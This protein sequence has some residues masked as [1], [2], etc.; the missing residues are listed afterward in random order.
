MPKLNEIRLLC[1]NYLNQKYG[2]K[3]DI[4]HE[5]MPNTEIM[6]ELSHFSFDQNPVF[7][8]TLTNY[9]LSLLDG[10]ITHIS[11]F[12]STSFVDIDLSAADFKIVKREGSELDEKELLKQLKDQWNN[13]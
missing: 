9:P 6:V 10:N 2:E 8:I 13:I 3:Y 11:A 5:E 1:S 7:T 4:K 12:F